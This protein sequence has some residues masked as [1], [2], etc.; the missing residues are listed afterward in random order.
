VRWV[1][2]AQTGEVA[3]RVDYDAFGRV[4]V[5]TASGWQ[6]FGFAG[7][8]W[9]SQVALSRLGARDY[10]PQTG[11]WASRDPIGFA[12]GS[13][14]L[15]TYAD[16]DPVNSFDPT[17]LETGYITCYPSC[18]G[19]V[20]ITEGEVYVWG[21]LIA[22]A[23]MP[24][25]LELA[26]AATTAGYACAASPA[27]ASLVPDLLSPN[28]G[29]LTPSV[30]PVSGM[31]RLGVTR[32]NP[33]AW[34]STRNLWDEVGYGSILSE[35][36]RSAIA[37]GRTPVVDEA[38]VR[39]F[40]ED[41]GLLGELIPQHHIGGTPFT[42]PMPATRHVEAHMPGGFRYNPGGPGAAVPSYPPKPR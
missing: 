23:A 21:G 39:Y 32:T 9:E 26:P 7:G 34:R 19:T 35:A 8:M 40:P 20:P 16:A 33:K 24:G 25:V 1:I 18:T 29:E 12:S 27:C 10:Q 41:A 14:G 11:T 30:T 6:P 42:V 38:W 37:A 28:P 4:V 15:Y 36:N 3:Q 13:A 2:N 22:L 17:G 31:T 5:D